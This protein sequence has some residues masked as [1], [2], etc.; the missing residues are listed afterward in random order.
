MPAKVERVERTELVKKVTAVEVVGTATGQISRGDQEADLGDFERI[1]GIEPTVMVERI[2][3]AAAERCRV[4]DCP[5]KAVCEDKEN[6]GS[7]DGD[8]GP[9][10][11]Y[12]Y[13]DR[14]VRATVTC[15]RSVSRK[16]CEQ[17]IQRATTD[18][19]HFF[20]STVHFGSSVYSAREDHMAPARAEATRIKNAAATEAQTVID[21]ASSGL[22]AVAHEV[23]VD[24]RA[25]FGLAPPAPDEVPPAIL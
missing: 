1:A 8:G 11:G 9:N 12:D 13:A 18:M 16:G 15:E 25:E 24:F 10:P 2:R 20:D 22:D 14:N 19:Q 17:V 6:R 3:Q 23:L 4:R 5:L 21:Q 7:V